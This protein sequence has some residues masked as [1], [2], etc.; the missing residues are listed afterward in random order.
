M[1]WGGK[2]WNDSENHW[3]QSKFK[4]K[5]FG[6]KQIQPNPRQMRCKLNSLV[7]FL[8]ISID[9][10][11][12]IFFIPSRRLYSSCLLIRNT[13]NEMIIDSLH[14]PGVWFNLV[15]IVLTSFPPSHPSTHPPNYPKTIKIESFLDFLIDTHRIL[16]GQLVVVT[17][18][19][20]RDHIPTVPLPIHQGIHLK[21]IHCSEI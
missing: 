4:R 21:D 8:F 3:D 7:R 18:V 12:R 16:L 2:G 17:S 10:M 19:G 1:E 15:P 6:S 11:S 9:I 5:P 13:S 20:A 14:L